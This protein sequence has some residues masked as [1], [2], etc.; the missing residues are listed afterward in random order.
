MQFMS[1]ITAHFSG[2][3]TGVSAHD[4]TSRQKFLNPIFNS[5]N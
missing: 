3:G 1:N 2:H 5:I 4:L